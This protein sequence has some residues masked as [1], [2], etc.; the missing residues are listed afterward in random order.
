MIPNEINLKL[1]KQEAI[2]LQ[3]MI[4]TSRIEKNEEE[5]AFQLLE[6]LVLL[7]DAKT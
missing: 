5:L 4:V 7:I 2:L 6:R 1:T 3:K